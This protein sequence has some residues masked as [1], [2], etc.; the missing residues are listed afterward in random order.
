MPVGWACAQRRPLRTLS[1]ILLLFDPEFIL[2]ADD[3]TYIN[4]D[5]LVTTYRSNIYGIMQNIPIV[6]GEFQGKPRHL[7]SKGLFVGGSG[8]FLS[9]AVVNR[10]ISNETIHYVPGDKYHYRTPELQ[11]ALSVAIEAFQKGSTTCPEDCVDYNPLKHPPTRAYPPADARDDSWKSQSG[12]L[13]NGFISISI[14]LV[15]LCTNMM[16]NEHTCLHSDHSLGRC[17]VYGANIVPVG[18]VCTRKFEYTNDTNILHDSRNRDH[19]DSRSIPDENGNIIS[20]VKV[21]DAHHTHSK[22]IQYSGMCFMSQT[23]DKD[24]ITCHRYKA[25]HNINEGLVLPVKYYTH[26][27]YFREDSSCEVMGIG[28]EATP[29]RWCD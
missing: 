20:Y 13:H 16:A 19:N 25:M 8:Y 2:M 14:P 21:L 29:L 11:R 5:R 7:T 18:M 15:Q 6:L 12:L 9:K 3:D 4:Y 28:K 17:L 24:K 26:R 1:H 22:H 23:C 27:S 10:L